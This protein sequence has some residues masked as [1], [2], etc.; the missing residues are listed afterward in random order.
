[1]LQ[2]SLRIFLISEDTPGHKATEIKFPGGSQD[3]GWRP[4]VAADKT[5]SAL[6]SQCFSSFEVLSVVTQ[7]LSV[8]SSLIHT[9]APKECSLPKVTK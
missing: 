5:D 4:T 2:I 7:K 3:M 8:L 6:L 9:E 1:M